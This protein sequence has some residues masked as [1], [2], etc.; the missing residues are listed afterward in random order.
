MFDPDEGKAADG[1]IV[2]GVARSRVPSAFEPVLQAAVQQ[3]NGR[4]LYLYGSVATGH[5]RQGVSDLDLLSVGASGRTAGPELSRQFAGLVRGVEISA[6]TAQD[7][8]GDSD[9]SYG[10]R[11]FL[12]HYCVL[13]VGPDMAAGQ[14]F[15]ADVRAA[16][17]FNGDIAQHVEVWRGALQ[18]GETQGLAR[19]IA[20][21]TLLALSGLVSVHDEIWTTDR[22]TAAARWSKVRPELAAGLEE[23]SLW[24]EQPI[25]CSGLE[26]Q[27]MMDD[28]VSPIVRDFRSAVGLWN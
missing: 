19:R 12:R 25:D 4:S 26:I 10:N 5:A 23:L 18:A 16:R 14:A 7:L 9:E 27:T 24:S 17:G 11:V 28:V 22:R 15:P 2:T 20:R 3:A 13:L 8:V 6:L 1:T 21:K